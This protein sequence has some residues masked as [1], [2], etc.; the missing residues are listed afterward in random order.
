MVLELWG[1]RL[2]GRIGHPQELK[3]QNICSKNAFGKCP[4]EKNAKKCMLKL[5]ACVW[6][7]FKMLKNAKKSFRK[8]AKNVSKNAK[9][10]SSLN[11]V[12]NAVIALNKKL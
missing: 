5:Q 8:C 10:L 1:S 9:K 7:L 2:A 3:L 4:L 11:G 6:V 12:W